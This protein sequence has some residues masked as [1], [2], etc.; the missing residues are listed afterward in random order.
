MASVTVTTWHSERVTVSTW[1]SECLT[2]STWQSECVAVPTW[3]TRVSVGGPRAS[4]RDGP[5]F[6]YYA[7]AAV[8][9]QNV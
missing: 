1:Q 7:D 2:V 4:L 3:Q 8:F 5:F 9:Q 6:S